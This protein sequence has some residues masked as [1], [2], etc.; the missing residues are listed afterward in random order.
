MNWGWG[1][2]KGREGEKKE[3][4]VNIPFSDTLHDSF[5]WG[6]HIFYMSNPSSYISY[7]EN[8]DRIR[9][10]FSY[11]VLF[12]SRCLFHH[13]EQCETALLYLPGG[14]IEIL[15]CICNF[16]SLHLLVKAKERKQNFW[17]GT[18]KPIF[19]IRDYPQIETSWLYHLTTI[20][21][22]IYIEPA[23]K[24]GIFYGTSL[25]RGKRELD[26]SMNYS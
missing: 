1:W 22:L 24:F 14:T 9:Q 26:G 5:I 13:Q 21:F 18:A 17:N 2:W 25:E 16:W 11:S 19:S 7:P 4:Q 23:W 8:I 10:L 6:K 3:L 12:P 15:Y 20:S